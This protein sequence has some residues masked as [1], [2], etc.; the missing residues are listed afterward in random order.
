[1]IVPILDMRFSL[2]SKFISIFVILLNIFIFNCKNSSS[3]FS[4]NNKFKDHSISIYR[5]ADERPIASGVLL[6]KNGYALTVFHA[7][8]GYEN[9]ISVSY[10]NFQKLKAKVV[11]KEF[12]FDLALIKIPELENEEGLELSDIIDRDK[13]SVG[14]DVYQF[15]SAYGLKNSLFKGYISHL[16]RIETDITYPQIP[17]I[18]T[19]GLSF[20]GSSGSGV[21]TMSGE[22]IGIQRAN[23]G[24]V[25]GGSVGLVIPGSF[26]K[27]FITNNVQ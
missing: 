22:C 27:L 16:N 2:D 21:F 7:V 24:Y 25:V 13:L 4:K 3:G 6:N 12:L 17:F 1:M 23:F 15:S 19:N 26:L 18:Q 10:A 14:D 9:K 11:A 8:T 20:P 5:E